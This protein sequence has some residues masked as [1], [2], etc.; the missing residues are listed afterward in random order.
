MKNSDYLLNR[1]ALVSEYRARAATYQAFALRL[2]DLL[3]VLLQADGVHIDHIEM[4]VKTLESFL[5][6]IEHKKYYDAPFDRIKDLIGL[7]IV[8]YYQDE[9]ERV[10][11]MIEREFTL[12]E[13]HSVDKTASL[14]ADRFGYRSLHLI[15]S[16]EHKRCVLPEWKSFAGIPAEIQVRSILQHAWA[17]FSREFDYK[18]P[19]QA[20]DALRRK[21]FQ[22]SAQLEGADQDFT[23]LRLRSEAIAKEYRAD[24]TQGQLELPLDL[25]SLREFM[26]QHVQAQEWER[27][28]VRVGMHPFPLLMKTFQS[29]GL[30]ILLRT[31]QEIGI[32]RLNEFERLFQEFQ[33]AEPHLRRFVEVV[34]A[35]GGSIHAVP[36]DVLVLLVS[37]SRADRIAPDFD[38][39]GKYDLTFL[40]TLRQVIAEIAPR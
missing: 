38:W 6:K 26:E 15:I 36:V 27:F 8:T 18:A 24:V 7:R 1:E 21:L 14:E 35:N 10:R 17:V 40:N 25:D 3:G 23:T 32:T 9:V 22:L 39:G 2:R 12:D 33:A 11:A 29:A 5:E 30:K 31:L 16:L 37:F 13:D 4:R 19:S 20:P 28:G 34:N